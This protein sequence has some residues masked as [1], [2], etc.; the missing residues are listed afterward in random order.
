MTPAQ[1]A[2]RARFN[3]E[4]VWASLP[5]MPEREELSPTKARLLGAFAKDDL[6]AV[7]TSTA[8]LCS[9][10]SVLGAAAQEGRRWGEF[11]LSGRDET[12]GSRQTLRTIQ[13]QLDRAGYL[14][15]E[16]RPQG[17]GFVGTVFVFK[18][19]AA[20]HYCAPE[21]DRPLTIPCSITEQDIPY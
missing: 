11:V 9:L 16:V 3:L 12:L 19:P 7:R 1:E 8:Y 5:R 14:T 17:H 4:V 21:V 6:K 2:A 13:A 18:P 20:L 10:S 15:A